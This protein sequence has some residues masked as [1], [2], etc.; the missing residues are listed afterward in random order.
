[1]AKFDRWNWD[2]SRNNQGWENNSNIEK[3]W[4]DIQPQDTEPPPEFQRNHLKPLGVR[5][6]WCNNFKS[7]K[8][9]FPTIDVST[10]NMEHCH[11]EEPK[12]ILEHLEMF[13]DDSRSKEG[14]FDLVHEENSLEK[15]LGAQ[16]SLPSSII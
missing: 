8:T 16:H 12:P 6:Q 1:M 5:Q 9:T 14:T 11:L 2:C 7:L 13:E 10:P 3:P 4:I 15:V